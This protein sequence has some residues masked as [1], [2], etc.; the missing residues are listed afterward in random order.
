MANSLSS[1]FEGF[2]GLPVNKQISLMILIS[3][4]IAMGVVVITWMR[5]P[6]WQTLHTPQ[7][8]RESAQIVDLLAKSNTP[9][10]IEEGS[11]AIQVD[12]SHFNDARHQLGGTGILGGGDVG[13]EMLS[14]QAIG[15][16]QFMEGARYQKAIEG[17]LARSISSMS[18][19][20]STRIHLAL[21]KQSPFLRKSRPPSAS[22]LIHLLPG[23][24]LSKETTDA[25]IHLVA[26]SVPNLSTELISVVDQT[27]RLH[28][29][30]RGGSSLDT[31]GSQLEHKLK[32]EQML[33]NRIEGI[34]S[35]IT[36][37]EGVRAEVTAEFD[38]DRVE[39]TEE[40]HDPQNLA[41]RSQQRQSRQEGGSIMAGG[42]PGALSNQPQPAATDN[43]SG[44]EINSAVNS[45]K[46]GQLLSDNS[47]TNYEV[48]RKISHKRQ[49]VGSIQRISIAVLVNEKSTKT[50]IDDTQIESIKELV[51]QA[52]GFDAARGDTLS[53]TKAVFLAPET[54]EATEPPIW[55]QGWVP[56]VIRQTV[57]GLMLFIII[58]LVMRPIM[59]N[60]SNHQLTRLVQGGGNDNPALAD[61]TGEQR[62]NELADDLLSLPDRDKNQSRLEFA[63]Q[64]AEA[65]PKQ[66]SQVVKDWI[67]SD[68]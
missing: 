52:S 21:P 18:G 28:S 53:V 33:V 24:Q 1:Q 55:E 25:I 35:P 68:A 54:I 47:V 8:F 60:L 22:V 17:E 5:A 23:R 48:D 62:R 39:Q 37:I 66:I 45:Q 61:H 11:G 41:V 38:F 57:G 3:A 15:T 50:A 31:S 44:S 7:S 4:T 10:Q 20:S 59:R 51:K 6:T 16:S 56:G 34:V 9:Y 13:F 65:D 30:A 64:V 58:F 29:G 43:G 42:V 14:E 63:K 49:A 26:A 67:A 2:T 12:A 32:V 40:T 36:G 46:T 19:I 27:G